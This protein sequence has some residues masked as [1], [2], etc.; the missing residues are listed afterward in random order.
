MERLKTRTLR[1]QLWLSHT[2]AGI[3]LYPTNTSELL[4]V[5]FSCSYFSS[6]AVL[7][8]QV[9]LCG[10][11]STGKNVHSW[12]VTGQEGLVINPSCLARW[13]TAGWSAQKAKVQRFHRFQ[14]GILDIHLGEQIW[15]ISVLLR[16][17]RSVTL[18]YSSWFDT[19]V[20]TVISKEEIPLAWQAVKELNILYSSACKG[21]DFQVAKSDCLSCVFAAPVSVTRCHRHPAFDNSIGEE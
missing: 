15:R 14:L 18:I 3:L 4:E 1:A 2:S 19:Y 9:I 5:L 13:P 7:D 8:I 6:E 10:T 21:L 16:D 17:L 12:I 11:P 20:C